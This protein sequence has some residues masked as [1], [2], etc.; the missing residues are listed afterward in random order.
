MER[1]PGTSDAVITR[2][3]GAMGVRFTLGQ[4]HT[5]RRVRAQ[6]AKA[7]L[8]MATPVDGTLLGEASGGLRVVRTAAGLAWLDGNGRIVAET[9][10]EEQYHGSVMGPVVALA[11]KEVEKPL[12][13]I[14]VGPPAAAAIAAAVP[15]VPALP[16]GLAAPAKPTAKPA[17]RRATTGP[18]TQPAPPA[19]TVPLV[20][21]QLFKDV[22]TK[23][24]LLGPAILRR[25]E[26]HYCRLGWTD[27][28]TV[29]LGV[30]LE[31]CLIVGGSA[32][33]AR[34]EDC[35]IDGLK[36]RGSFHDLHGIDFLRVT[37]RGRIDAQ[38]IFNDP[39]TAMLA[40]RGPD[41]WALD[42]ANAS[43]RGIELR[44]VPSRLVRRDPATQ[45]VVRRQRALEGKWR[46]LDIGAFEFPLQDLVDDPAQEDAVLV[47][48]RLA[49]NFGEKLAA[50]ELLR[51][52]GIAEKD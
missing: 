44:S 52:H 33:R 17:A 25:C 42:I 31:R 27:H 29:V 9:E 16:V 4:P 15:A 35:C 8:S 14:G 26:L 22:E 19:T 18:R 13:L 34:L 11:P 28:D 39:P 50:L 12:L 2:R 40:R 32:H 20:E 5:V 7:G 3:Y 38:L 24:P 30:T 36:M 10:L 1:V 49:K 37:L 45:F 6:S 41:E 47:A 21:S 48:C 43:F 46:T 23:A 51:R